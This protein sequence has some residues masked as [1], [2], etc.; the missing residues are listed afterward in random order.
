[1][2]CWTSHPNPRILRHSKEK[3]IL[4]QYWYKLKTLISCRICN[5]CQYIWC[6]EASLVSDWDGRVT[7]GYSF[8][9]SP[10][11]GVLPYVSNIGTFRPMSIIF[12]VS[13]QIIY[14]FLPP[15]PHNYLR[16]R[17]PSLRYVK[18]KVMYVL[19]VLNT[20]MFS[21]RQGGKII[22]KYILRMLA[23]RTALER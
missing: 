19:M 2:S 17:V 3:F 9:E 21:L 12:R 4:V 7:V 18:R 15:R 23:C 11:G 14:S 6:I 13:P 16:F 22:L 20:V 10:R 8:D 1:M 5:R